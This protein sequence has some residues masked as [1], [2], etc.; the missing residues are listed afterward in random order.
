MASGQPQLSSSLPGNPHSSRGFRKALMHTQRTSGRLKDQ[1]PDKQSFSGKG[2][3]KP[4]YF[5]QGGQRHGMH[6]G[7][8]APF[9]GPAT[10]DAGAGFG[11]S[12]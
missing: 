8:G 1:L 9:T 6:I 4:S 3:R 2:Y 5:A 11:E 12:D 7:S 10:G